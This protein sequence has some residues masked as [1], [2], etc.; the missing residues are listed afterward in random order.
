MYN[1]LQAEADIFAF[2]P[3]DTSSGRLT[4][5]VLIE[6]CDME[7]TVTIINRFDHFTA[8]VQAPYSLLI[9]LASQG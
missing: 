4:L 1:L 6:F 8:E 5:R 9:Q 3:E 7:E 2:I